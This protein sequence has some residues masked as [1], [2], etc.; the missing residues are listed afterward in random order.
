MHYTTRY[1]LGVTQIQQEKYDLAK[2]HFTKTL[3]FN[4]QSSSVSSWNISLAEEG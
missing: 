2:Y 3:S 4:P 1:D